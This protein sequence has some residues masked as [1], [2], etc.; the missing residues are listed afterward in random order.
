MNSTVCAIDDFIVILSVFVNNDLYFMTET[1]QLYS[2]Y[3]IVSFCFTCFIA[4]HFLSNIGTTYAD[5]IVVLLE[6][7]KQ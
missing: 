3:L 6:K 4:Y 5:I 1:F 7:L 2:F